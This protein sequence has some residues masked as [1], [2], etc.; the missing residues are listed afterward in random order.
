MT[1]FLASATSTDLICAPELES[2]PV[3]VSSPSAEARL[4]P[5][6]PLVSLSEETA[7]GSS[8]VNSVFFFTSTS[9]AASSVPMMSA[10][11]CTEAR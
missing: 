2:E 6:S 4:I 5:S 11:P 1:S 7:S 8:A 10:V 9:A 3:A